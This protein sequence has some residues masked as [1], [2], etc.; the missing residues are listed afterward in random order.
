MTYGV[1][2][3]ERKLKMCPCHMRLNETRHVIAYLKQR[4]LYYF[5]TIKKNMHFVTQSFMSHT[6]LIFNSYYFPK[7]LG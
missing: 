2:F 6:F 3:S 4:G 1:Y 5:K 7:R